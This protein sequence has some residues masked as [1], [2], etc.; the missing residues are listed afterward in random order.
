MGDLAAEQAHR[1]GRFVYRLLHGALLR[2]ERDPIANNE[3][4]LRRIPTN[5]EY[6][7]PDLPERLQRAAFAPNKQDTDGISFYRELFISRRHLAK[8]T[9]RKPPYVVCRIRARQVPQGLT[10]IASPD[11]DLSQPRGHCTIPQIS[12]ETRKTTVE[13]Q[14]ELRK[15]VSVVFDRGNRGWRGKLLAFIL[16]WLRT[17]KGTPH[18]FTLFA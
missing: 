5:A 4:L 13:L 16:R 9:G 2:H 18:S 14:I 12:Y 7:R 6:Y 15:Q 8:H 17:N 3:W 1:V 10:V 11:P